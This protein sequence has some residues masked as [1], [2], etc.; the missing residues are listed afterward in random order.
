[1][2]TS[3][4]SII[5]ASGPNEGNIVI[6]R[7]LDRVL[8][9]GVQVGPREQ[10]SLLD[11]IQNIAEDSTQPVEIVVR[12]P[13]TV[14][15]STALTSLVGDQT[16]EQRQQQERSRQARRSPA[17][18]RRMPARRPSITDLLEAL[19]GVPRLIAQSE[20]SELE[21]ILHHILMHEQSQRG[22][23]AASESIIANL[24]RKVVQE[25]EVEEL[26]EC[27]IT[28]EKFSPGDVCVTL[29]CGHKYFESQIVHWLGMHATCPVCRINLNEEPTSS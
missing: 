6:Q 26:G 1:M 2:S 3:R 12:Q 10:T 22:V 24:D 25:S 20:S 15:D 19:I 18:T 9:M 17:P 5:S 27:N 14:E 29:K 8:G 28:F 13:L 11:V 4:V 16:E 21:N 23:P 7:I